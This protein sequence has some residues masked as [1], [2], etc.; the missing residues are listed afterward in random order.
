MK[1][2]LYLAA[3]VVAA[4]SLT[5][6]LRHTA[7]TPHLSANVD[8]IPVEVFFPNPPVNSLRPAIVIAH[9]YAGSKQVMYELA[10]ALTP[11]FVTIVF[12]FS[13]HG[14]NPHPFPTDDRTTHLD[15]DLD[16]VVTY[17]R[18]LPFVDP[19]H[20][21][22]LG[23]S[24]GASAVVRYAKDHSDVDGVV[25]ISG[26]Y[27]DVSPGAPKNLLLLAGELEFPSI[28]Q[29]QTLAL[30]NAGGESEYHAEEPARHSEVIPGV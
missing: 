15:A 25:G 27:T 8:G 9:G 19:N 1:R 4:L 20:I 3:F 7:E 11:G 14:A 30:Q 22:V 23:H 16:R 28:K 10:Q 29:A 21:V 5:Q 2:L 13:G 18:S 17:A 24:M 26:S 6:I 12:D